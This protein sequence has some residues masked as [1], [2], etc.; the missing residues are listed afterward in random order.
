MAEE[1]DNKPLE[2]EVQDKDP[3]IMDGVRKRV[4]EAF[5][6]TDL[7]ETLDDIVFGEVIPA[8]KD[9]IWRMASGIVHCLVY[10][11]KAPGGTR[12]SRYRSD[13]RYTSYDSYYES[14]KNNDERRER[15]KTA[16]VV[17]Y[18]PFRT[19]QEAEDIL[20]EMKGHINEYGSISVR[21]FYR[22]ISEP[23]NY[24]MDKYGWYD[25][26]MVTVET[27]RYGGYIL[28]LPDPVVL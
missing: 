13:G 8:I 14:F 16:N 25:L 15:R 24:T 4:S 20:A 1:K 3:S 5:K 19:R 2:G 7:S 11:R 23:D 26:S 22:I 17:E 27:G 21:Q 6:L 12:Y 10:G 28:A 9:T 18:E